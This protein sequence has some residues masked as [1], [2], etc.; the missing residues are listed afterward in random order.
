MGKMQCG[1]HLNCHSVRTLC[2]LL[3]NFF[4]PCP[5]I[6]LCVSARLPRNLGCIQ[7]TNTQTRLKM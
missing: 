7:V 6:V 4:F 2:S 3:G 5:V 1:L